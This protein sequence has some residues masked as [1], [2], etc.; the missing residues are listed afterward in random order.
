MF[1]NQTI[2]TTTNF[3]STGVELGYSVK[4]TEY[5]YMDI[6]ALIFNAGLFFGIVF[7]FIKKRK[8]V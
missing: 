2:A 1:Y 7:A 6:L 8:K 3:D 5:G 4:I